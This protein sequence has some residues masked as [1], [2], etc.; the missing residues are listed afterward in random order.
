MADVY[1]ATDK[2]R[3]HDVAVKLLRQSDP[4][5]SDRDRFIAE[6]KTLSSLNHPGLVTVLDVSADH[7]RL[8]LVM[9][10]V[11]GEP[12]SQLITSGPLDPYRLAEIGRQ[13]ADAV[14]YV[15]AQ[16][17]VHRDIKPANILVGEND[18]VYLADFGIA[19]ILG[20]LRHH[21]A[22]GFTMGTAAYV[23]PE[24]VQGR[25]VTGATDVYSLGLVLLEALTGKQPFQGTAAEMSLA[26]LA[27]Q[28]TIPDSFDGGWRD[29]LQHMTA[30]EPSARPAI[31]WVEQQLTAITANSDMDATAVITPTPTLPLAV[32]TDP[33]DIEPFHTKTLP[34]K[35]LPTPDLPQASEPTDGAALASPSPRDRDDPAPAK[36]RIQR[37]PGGEARRHVGLR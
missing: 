34:T 15:H 35:D 11:E 21:T 9:E 12:L 10:L 19:R 30:I 17:F 13:L 23:S 25:H 24:Q 29:V 5:D 6:A 7:D 18:H 1:R 26:R 22:T 27:V 16:G 31:A 3:T 33:A 4:A 36:A 2:H 8:Y 28:P 32:P 14:G 20:D 37:R